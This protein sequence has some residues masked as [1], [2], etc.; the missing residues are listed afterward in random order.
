M[1]SSKATLY[2]PKYLF[3]YWGIGIH[4]SLLL[5][6]RIAITSTSIPYYY[7]SRCSLADRSLP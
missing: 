5:I 6:L 1:L 2:E 3:T 4:Y 7:L